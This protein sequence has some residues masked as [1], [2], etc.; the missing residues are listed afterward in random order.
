MQP[1]LAGFSWSFTSDIVAVK[2]LTHPTPFTLY[3]D[4]LCAGAARYLRV[5]GYF[6]WLYARDA[7]CLR[8][9]GNGGHKLL[10]HPTSLTLFSDWLC[11]GDA[12]SLR[13]PGDG[14][15]KINCQIIQPHS[16]CTLIG[17]Y[18]SFT[19]H[20]VAVKGLNHP[21]SLTLFFGCVKQEMR[22]V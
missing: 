8:G 2:G 13:G 11:A 3:F 22:A 18:R 7:R 12:H 21:T 4:W 14:G 20:I 1:H 19:S 6:V 10:N 5:V 16:C 17:F 15:H 9:L